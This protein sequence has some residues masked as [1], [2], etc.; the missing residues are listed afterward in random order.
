MADVPLGVFLSGGLDSS[1][2]A[3]LV[4]RQITGLH[5]FAVGLDGSSDLLAARCAAA[6]LGTRHH[7][8]VYTPEELVHA[9]PTVIAH[10]ESY[11]PALI[12]SA[13]P[14][15]FVS[16]L[17]SQHVKVV[18]TGEGSDEAF[19]GYRY[20]TNIDDPAALH[21]E[22][23]RL[24]LG[25]HNMNLQRVDR[26]T[27]AHGLEGRVPFLDVDFLTWAMGLDPAEKLHHSSRPEKWLLRRACEGLLPAEIAWRRKQ[28][29]AE[30]C[31]SEGVLK[32][33]SEHAVTEADLAR[34]SEFFPVD[35]PTTKEALL[36]RRLF[37]E[38]FPGE[39]H[40]RTVGRWRGDVVAAS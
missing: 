20:F 22:C 33:H 18:L 9:L 40:R 32:D 12:R 23:A 3:A 6:H 11:D 27:M 14:C 2:I 31:G 38:M 4:R 10:L 34:A 26:M 17:T 7:E 25:L 19:A 35:T 5:S 15:Y 24:L 29:F 37:E 28:E 36:Y 13:V 8:R 21:R 30:G 16:E 39:A 1:M